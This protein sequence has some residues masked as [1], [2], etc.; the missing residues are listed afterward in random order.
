MPRGAQPEERLA[1]RERVAVEQELLLRLYVRHLRGRDVRRTARFAA[2]Q[3]MLPVLAIARVIGVGPVGL[4]NRRIVLLDTAFYFGEQRLLQ[5]FGLGEDA[6]AIVVLGLQI[7]AYRRIELRRIAHH[8]APVLRL[9][10]G[11]FI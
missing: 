6:L 3:G 11:I 1:L 10:P 5:A 2:Q 9:E 7:G 4:G 8:F